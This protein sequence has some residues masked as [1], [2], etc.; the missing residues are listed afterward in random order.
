MER[1]HE[2]L[3]VVALDDPDAVEQM[4]LGEPRA[5]GRAGGRAAAQ[6]VDELVDAAR[7]DDT[8]DSAGKHLPPCQLHQAAGLIRTSAFSSCLR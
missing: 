8:D 7:A 3:D 1:R 5:A 2:H 4:L 6:L